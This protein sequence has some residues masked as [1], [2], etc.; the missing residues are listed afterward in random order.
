MRYA[1][2]RAAPPARLVRRPGDADEPQPAVRAGDPRHV[3]GRGIGIIDTI[4][5]VEV[6]RAIEVLRTARRAAATA[7]CRPIATWFADYLR[8]MTTH[9]TAIDERDAK[10]NHG[11][12]WVMQVAAFA[13]SPAT[14]RR[15]EMCRDALQDGAAADADGG[16]RQLS[17][18]SSPAPSPTATRCSISTRWRRSARSSPTPADN[19]WTFELPDGRG[20]RKALAFMVPFIRD[21]KTWP[22]P[23]DVMYRRRVADAAR[24]ACCSAASRWTGPTISSSGRPSS[25]IRTSRKSIRN[26]FIRQPLL[27]VD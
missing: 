18:A 8:W 17:R 23:P 21:K 4:H 19:L 12:C 1:D 10:N 14:S 9:H 13:R 7:S 24:R 20:M 26:F 2:A 11:T 25:L 22:H 6:A 15:S 3:T 16:G 5:L 27:W